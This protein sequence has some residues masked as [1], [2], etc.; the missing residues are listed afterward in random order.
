MRRIVLPA[1]LL[2]VLVIASAG[3]LL[4]AISP[5][6]KTGDWLAY[7]VNVSG[8][9]SADHDLKSATLTVTS[10]E[11]DAIHLSVTSEFNNGTVFTEQITL[12][13]AEGVLGDA[14]FIPSNLNVGD[15]FYDVHQGNITITGKQTRLVAGAERSVVLS[16]TDTTRYVWDHK[17]GALVY[18]KTT[19]QNFT[20]ETSIDK[21]N[22]WPSDIL[23]FTPSI[24]YSVITVVVILIAVL[25][26]F[27]A[28]WIQQK[29][30]K[31][32]L[33]ALEATGAIFTAV[34]LISYLGGML[35][36]PSTTVLH[37]E[38]PVRITLFVV[39]AALLTLIVTNSI[40]VLREKAL[41][42]F[43]ALKA[44]LFTVAVA[45]FLFTLHSLFTLEWIGEWERFGSGSLS[46]IILI[47]DISGVVGILARF[48]AGIIALTVAILYFCKRLPS[49]QRL[50]KALRWILV[51]EATYWFALIPTAITLAY[52]AAV[53]YRTPMGLL[54]NLAWTTIPA[55]VE[56]I[57]LPSA[58]VIF[59]K[60]LDYKKPAVNAIKWAWISGISLIVVFWLTNMGSWML[61]VGTKGFSYLIGYPQNLF[62]FLITVGGLIALALYTLYF[63]KK[64]GLALT[65]QT[66]NLRGVGVII[67]LLGLYFLWNYL[68]WIFFGGNY[69]WSDWYAWSLGH[70]LDLW[71]L[72]L[73][74]VGI[75]L[76]LYRPSKE[77]IVI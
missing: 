45:Y 37:S 31:L 48:I 58:L 15:Q 66:L 52:I 54:S 53:F 72:T 62:S 65:W 5:G 20:I 6:V 10:V 60:K 19:G 33:L 38:L 75:P 69:I 68:N 16:S 64:R 18:A 2:V 1:I 51:L 50:H 4:S 26:V 43:S 34:F 24:F 22:L 61:T 49:T 23:N 35:M 28:I 55:F 73:P 25:A 74:L 76:M 70:N 39:G 12:N 17:T 8:Y 63:T 11:G 14:F 29:K 9:P 46:T 13:L 30:Q 7:H 59:A 42:S 71:M 41:K 27:S 77:S 56:S 3:G 44:G 57:V 21:T 47:Q 40:M 67:T 32:L 36:T